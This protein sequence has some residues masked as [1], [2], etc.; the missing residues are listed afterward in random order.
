[1]VQYVN[2]IVYMDTAMSVTFEKYT[3][4]LKL[5]TKTEN[6]LLTCR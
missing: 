5:S 2:D 1:M 4:V 6:D 3:V